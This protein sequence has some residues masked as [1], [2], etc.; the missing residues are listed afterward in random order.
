[1]IHVII[2][3]DHPV[4][5]QGIKRILDEEADIQVVGEAGNGQELIEK[6]DRSPCDVVVL[7][8]SMPGRDGLDTLSHLRRCHPKI[9]VFVLSVY[10][11]EQFGSRVLRAGAAGYMN[12]EAAC[13]QL[14]PAIRKV[15]AGGKYVSPNLAEKIAC[16]L[17]AD[18]N[19][20]PHQKLSDREY[21]VMRLIASGKTVSEIAREL[22]LSK[23]T[24]STH[25][26]R[27]LEK[28]ELKTNAQLTYYA[29]QRELVAPAA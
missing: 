15:C 20:P 4:V 29:L 6:V 27:I 24:I 13:D 25:R 12:K 11:E 9:P 14:V 10:P 23:K 19:L 26:A 18:N 5:R 16:D 7:D 1:M 22:C 3:D 28:M 17:A 8:I 2:A 21:Q